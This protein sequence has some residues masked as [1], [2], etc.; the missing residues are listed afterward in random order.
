MTEDHEGDCVFPKILRQGRD[1]LTGLKKGLGGKDETHSMD[2]R[3]TNSC[4]G[5]IP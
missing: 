4:F 2:K 1:F 5:F 3:Q